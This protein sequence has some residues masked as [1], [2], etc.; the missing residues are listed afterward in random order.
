MRKYLPHIKLALLSAAL[1]V[2]Y[3][4]VGPLFYNTWM[5]EDYTHGFFVP[6]VSAYMVWADREKFK[7][8]APRPDLVTGALL[9]ALS[10]FLLVYGA[11]AGVSALQMYSVLVLAPGLVVMVLGLGW[12]RAMLLPVAYLLLMVPIPAPFI[13]HVHWPLQV[14]TSVMTSA[15]LDLS[16]IPVLRNI[17]FLELPNATLEVA[18]E[19]SGL[20]FLISMI[21]VGVP[22]AH[23]T[24][25]TAWK[26]AA[27][28]VSA[29]ALGLFA[30][31][32]RVFI[33][34]CWVYFT[35]QESH[36]FIHILKGMVVSVAGFFILFALSRLLNRNDQT[37]SEPARAPWDPGKSGFFMNR[38]ASAA[39]VIFAALAVFQFSHD[40]ARVKFSAP[41]AQT[42]LPS[43]AGWTGRPAAG[44]GS[45]FKLSGADTEMTAEYSAPDGRTVYAYIG[46]LESQDQERELINHDANPFQKKSAAALMDLGGGAQAAV[47]RR[48][49][50]RGPDR[51]LLH[52]WYN[53]NGRPVTDKYRALHYFAVDSLLHGRNNGA[54]VM[55]FSKVDGD[56]STAGAENLHREFLAAFHPAV[57]GWFASSSGQARERGAR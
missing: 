11:A 37:A 14:V 19:C 39:T 52:F 21:A 17:Q 29:L 30:N 57:N 40:T 56:G 18:P 1:L 36:G 22:L 41:E 26:K 43:I 27:I 12:L 7:G 23:L 32:L 33:A 24:Q 25:K 48:V 49:I 47:S 50:S 15:A 42:G 8:M 9:I 28:V 10:A 55:V 34:G 44:F 16:G 20:N 5:H 6:F 4:R 53:I 2:A 3:A 51:Y 13:E 54:V 38:G 31:W 35:G 45:P 46:Y